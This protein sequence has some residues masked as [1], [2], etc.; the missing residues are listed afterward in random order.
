MK[1]CKRY[2]YQ[3]RYRLTNVRSSGI[4][5][6]KRETNREPLIHSCWNHVQLSGIIDGAQQF[7]IQFVGTFCTET[8]QS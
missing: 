8:D 5:R 4:R 1:T 3:W 2:H 6:G 7:L